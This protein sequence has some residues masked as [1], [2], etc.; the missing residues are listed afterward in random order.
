MWVSGERHMKLD[1]RNMKLD[2]AEFPE[3]EAC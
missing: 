1:E 3:M 2:V